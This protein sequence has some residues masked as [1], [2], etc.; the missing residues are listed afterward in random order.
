MT[1][2]SIN[3]NKIALLRNSREGNYP[4]PVD[5]AKICV[6]SGCHGITVHPRP[7]QRHIRPQDVEEL[8]SYCQAL[9]Q[10]EFNIEG[11][12]FAGPS[13][14]FKGGSYPG[15][16]NL[17]EHQRPD[18]VTLVPDSDDQLTSDH[19]FNLTI[20]ADRIRPVIEQLKQWG[21][22]VSLFMDPDPEQIRLA[23]TVGA[24]RIELY[25]GPYAEHFDLDDEAFIELHNRYLNA[26]LVAQEV[27]LGV[28]AGHDL[29]LINLRKFIEIPNILEVSIGHAFTADSLKMGMAN[30]TQAYLSA[31]G[32]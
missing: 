21:S 32:H 26:A 25:T 6:D 1:A 8:G 12:P 18:Q 17:I 28:N 10:I 9:P 22:R 15:F 30:C 16:M 19:G 14:G 3:L 27:G 7:D 4:N 23:A 11:N 29:N 2:L 5:F 24:D 31:L 13:N 20:D